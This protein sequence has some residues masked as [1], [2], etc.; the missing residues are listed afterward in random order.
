MA[1]EA[2][3]LPGLDEAT[4]GVIV[5]SAPMLILVFTVKLRWNQR[6]SFWMASV[7]DPTNRPIVRDIK[8][9]EGEDI[10]ENVIRPYAPSGAIVCRDRT[11]GDRDPGR[12]GWRE[13]IRLMYEVEVSGA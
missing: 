2:R 5:V 12:D 9:C 4:K 7:Y 3:A 8:V 11:G 13:G 10:L 6:E 1:F